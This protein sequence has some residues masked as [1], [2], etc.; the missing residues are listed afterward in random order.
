MKLPLPTTTASSCQTIQATAT[1]PW[2]DRTRT[3]AAG[4]SRRGTLPRASACCASRRAWASSRSTIDATRSCARN[5]SGTSAPSS[6]RSPR[7]CSTTPTKTRARA[8]WIAGSWRNSRAASSPS[9][10]PEIFQ[11]P[12]A[13]NA[14]GDATETCTALTRA[15]PTRGPG[16]RG[17]SVSDPWVAN[18]ASP[19]P[20]S[21]TTPKK[22]TISSRSPL[23][24]YSKPLTAP[25]S[26]ASPPSRKRRLLITAL[27]KSSRKSTWTDV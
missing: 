24:F 7:A 18:G 14:T 19:R 15:R 23:E 4:C 2:R 20:R 13:S 11:C 17:T 3:E 21:S 9:R 16:T 1:S 25:N 27:P 12:N 10:T 5:A 22:Q 6:V 26:T 8:W